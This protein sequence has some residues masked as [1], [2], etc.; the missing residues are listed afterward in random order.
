MGIYEVGRKVDHN[1]VVRS[2]NMNTE[3]IV[4]KL[5][6]VLGKTTD[7]KKV[8]EMMETSI[9]ADITYF[10]EILLSRRLT[11]IFGGYITPDFGQNSSVDEV[12]LFTVKKLGIF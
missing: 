6:W 9:A 12:D 8:K 2:K 3:A 11:Q 1:R 5:M 4:P 7:P 10:F